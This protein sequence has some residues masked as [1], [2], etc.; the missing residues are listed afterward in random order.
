MGNV[1]S[2]L[3]IYIQKDDMKA[4]KTWILITL[5]LHRNRLLTLN[6]YRNLQGHDFNIMVSHFKHNLSE[7]ILSV[8]LSL[9][10]KLLNHS[11]YQMK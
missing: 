3:E 2:I 4:E 7:H 5:I 9:H 1:F 10:I 11:D 8:Q 6:V